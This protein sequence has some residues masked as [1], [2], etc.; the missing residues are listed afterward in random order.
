MLF[1]SVSVGPDGAAS[2]EPEVRQTQAV[3]A[4][5][6]VLVY[7]RLQAVLQSQLAHLQYVDVLVSNW[8]CHLPES[9][10]SEGYLAY[11]SYERE[12]ERFLLHMRTVLVH[13]SA[14]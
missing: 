9:G 13:L 5:W 8:A 4:H 7:R 10:H 2:I 3:T 1:R 11:A 12:F 6:L 14:L